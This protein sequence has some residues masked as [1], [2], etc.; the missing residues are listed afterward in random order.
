MRKMVDQFDDVARQSGA[1]IVS[2]CGHDCVP[3]DLMALQCAKQLKKSGESMN[4]VQTH[5]F[6]GINEL[7]YINF[8]CLFVEVPEIIANGTQ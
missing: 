2:F 1:R 5:R 6:N 7:Y 8:V 3:W 4:E